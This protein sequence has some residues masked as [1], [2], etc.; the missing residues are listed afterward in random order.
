MQFFLQKHLLFSKKAV[1]LCAE[2]TNAGDVDSPPAI[3]Y[4][5]AISSS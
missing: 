2:M 5:I 4:T 1:L 3:G